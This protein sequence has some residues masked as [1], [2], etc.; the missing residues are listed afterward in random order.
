M[1]VGTSK[2]ETNTC[3]VELLYLVYNVANN[4]LHG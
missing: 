3:K 2:G 1:G 4:S